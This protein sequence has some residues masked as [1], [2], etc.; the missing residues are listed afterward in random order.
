MMPPPKRSGLAPGTLIL[1]MGLFL[2]VL[3]FAGTFSFHAVLRVK[4]TLIDGPR[5]G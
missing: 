1:P 4:V 5:S 2:G 3:I